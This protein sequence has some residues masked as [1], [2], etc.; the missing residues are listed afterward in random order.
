CPNLESLTIPS[1]V[2]KL[3]AIAYSS[4]A[5][6]VKS[7]T[8]ERMDLSAVDIDQIPDDVVIY[9]QPGAT[10]YDALSKNHLVL[11]V[12]QSAPNYSITLSPSVLDFG[13]VTQYAAVPAGQT[14]TLTNTGDNAVMVNQGLL[15]ESQSGSSYRSYK[16]DFREQ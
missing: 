15:Y 7:I 11:T 8:F 1:S 4:F 6:Y 10:G 3:G 16:T 12:G 5:S 13:T 2:T 9:V 14:M